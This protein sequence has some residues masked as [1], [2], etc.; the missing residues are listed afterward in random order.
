MLADYLPC[1]TSVRLPAKPPKTL[2]CRDPGDLA[3]LQLAVVGKADYLVTGDR[4]LP[5]LT[6]RLT[7]PII[8]PDRMLAVIAKT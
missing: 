7:C 4:D 2:A 5:A 1:C 3:Y 6:G 8:A